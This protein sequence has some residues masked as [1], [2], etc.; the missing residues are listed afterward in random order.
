MILAGDVLV[1]DR[2]VTKAGSLV[3]HQATIRVSQTF[4]LRQSWWVEAKEPL[5][6]SRSM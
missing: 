6:S 5:K 2:P 4:A 1:D 3:E